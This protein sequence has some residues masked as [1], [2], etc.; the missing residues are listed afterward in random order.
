MT[1][2][3]SAVQQAVVPSETG[4]ALAV[5][6]LGR[7]LGPWV[8][9]PIAG[10]VSWGHAMLCALVL[11]AAALVAQLLKAVLRR[12]ARG[13]EERVE[14]D[15]RGA[16]RRRSW[17]TM[18]LEALLPPLTLYVWLWGGFAVLLLLVALVESERGWTFGR[19]LA[20]WLKWVGDVGA[21]FWFLMR[22]I[23]VVGVDLQRLAART[24]SKWDDVLLVLLLRALRLLVPLA[25]AILV[26]PTLQL[27]SSLETLFKQATSLALIGAVGFIFVQLANAV[28]DAVLG[29][30]RVDSHDNLEAR[31]VYT[32]VKVLKKIALFTIVLFTSSSMLMV[33]EPV[34]QLGTSILA[35]AGVVGVIV[36]FAAQRSIAT[37]LAGF[38]IAVT[39]PIRLDDVVIVENEWGRIE[40]ISLTYVVVNIWD[41]RRLV[42][43]ISH[44]IEKPF[45]NW[46]RS[47]TDLLGTVFLYLDYTVPLAALREELDRLLAGS[48]LWD[49]KVKGIQVTDAKP[50]CME[51]RVLASSPDASA[52]WDLRCELREKLLDFVQRRYP[53][54]LPRARAELVR[55]A[56]SESTA[57]S[58]T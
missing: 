15:K 38:Q 36:G 29:Q 39:Q 17:I 14:S 34:R 12:L 47:S 11:A 55:D 52:G 5:G 16:P 35:S 33:F 27:P 24:A 30:F 50:N 10:G 51:V 2:T 3:M 32:Q 13:Q 9:T 53:S 48:P 20:S 1:M 57:S 44:F 23:R 49:G 37:V 54:G 18:T 40:E 21:L 31:K 45:Q 25:G 19:P 4:I 58:A 26:V 56:T 42:V 28:E 7:W 8:E 46:T 6:F 22:M 43:P 41:K